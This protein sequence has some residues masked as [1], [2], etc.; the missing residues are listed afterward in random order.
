MY[1]NGEGKLVTEA[2][3]VYLA[4]LGLQS[5]F[6]QVDIELNQRLITA[7]CGFLLSLQSVFRRHFKQ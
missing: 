7:K 4:N 6:R 2:D 1:H 5:L 3:K